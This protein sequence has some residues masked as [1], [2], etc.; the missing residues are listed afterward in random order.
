MTLPSYTSLL[1]RA[2]YLPKEPVLSTP[3]YTRE[4]MVED[5]EWLLSQGES[6]SSILR[7]LDRTA[8]ATTRGLIRAGRMDLAKHF[9]SEEWRERR[10]RANAA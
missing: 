1:R 9:W 8:S 7:R 3:R 5:V 4:D 10:N 2:G 6:P